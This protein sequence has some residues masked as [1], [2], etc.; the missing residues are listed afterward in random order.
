M[1]NLHLTLAASAAALLWLGL[2]APTAQAE[3]DPPRPDDKVSTAIIGGKD[4]TEPYSFMASLQDRQGEH[5]CGGSLLNAEWV[6]TALHC[7][8]EGMRPEDLRLRI[9]SL[10]K[11]RDG[12]ARGAEQIVLYPGGSPDN[13]DVG[14]VRLDEPVPNAPVPL[15]VRQPA[16]TPTRLLGWGCTAPGPNTGCGDANV[17]EVLQ[18]LDSAVREPAACVNVAAPIHPDNEVCTGNPDTRTGPCFADSGGPLLHQTAGGWRLIGAFSRVDYPN[19]PP[20]F[21]DCRTGLGIYSDVTVHREW[22]E[23]VIS[24]T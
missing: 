18:Q 1:R 6:V 12:S 15:D 13:F 24:A 20:D 3:P 22:I 21:P 9:G 11:D 8:D 16:G 10:R 23:S 5:F 17:P 4:A 14:L 2:A 19:G 7:V